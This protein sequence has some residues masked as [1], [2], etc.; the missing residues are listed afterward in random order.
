MELLLLSVETE[1]RAEHGCFIVSVILE[2]TV[3]LRI[4]KVHRV[5]VCLLDRLSV[6]FL[7][8]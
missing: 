3:S 2:K 7:Y 5:V 1:P 4:I 6:S 8:N